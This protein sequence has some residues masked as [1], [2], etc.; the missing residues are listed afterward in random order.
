MTELVEFIFNIFIAII[1]ILPTSPFLLMIQKVEEVPV[2]GVV[3]WFIPFDICASLL[4]AWLVVVIAYYAYKNIH[5][6]LDW[7]SKLKSLF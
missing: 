7:I 2:L 1:S 4:D 3:N 6:I 5:N